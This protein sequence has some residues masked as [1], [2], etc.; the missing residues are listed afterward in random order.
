MKTRTCHTTLLL[1]AVCFGCAGQGTGA[2][3]TQ[4][5]VAPAAAPSAQASNAP[6]EHLD[7]DGRIALATMERLQLLA[8]C[9]EASSGVL[10]LEVGDKWKRAEAE[11]HLNHLF[12]GY[13]THV[14]PGRRVV[15]ELWRDRKKVGEYTIDGLLYDSEFT[16]RR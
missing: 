16:P 15:L 7:P 5:G 11:Y 2:S 13:S 3:G 6:C 12:N 8:G 9:Q 10:H 4:E 14:E 1:A